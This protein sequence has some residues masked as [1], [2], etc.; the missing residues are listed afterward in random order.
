MLLA[1]LKA[2]FAQIETRL[3]SRTG[4]VTADLPLDSIDRL[5]LAASG[6]ADGYQTP[7][8]GE[9]AYSNTLFARTYCRPAA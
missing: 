4:D 7:P 2:G 1:G 6:R 5:L 3:R 9:E 8:V